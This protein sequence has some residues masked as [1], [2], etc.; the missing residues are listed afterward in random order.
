M[1]EIEAKEKLNEEPLGNSAGQQ[2]ASVGNSGGQ[3]RSALYFEIRRK[4]NPKNP[5]GW[6]K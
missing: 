4:G 1:N 2:I 6:V 5:M 3:N